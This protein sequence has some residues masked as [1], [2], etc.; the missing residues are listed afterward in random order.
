MHGGRGG[1]KSYVVDKS[2]ITF[3]KKQMRY[4]FQNSIKQ[5]VHALIKDQ[6]VNLKL[7]RYFK[8]KRDEIFCNL[9]AG[10]K[11]TTTNQKN[12]KFF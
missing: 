10:V 3:F 11:K 7:Q 5:G 1:G 6:I 2:L 9:T 8:V 4:Q 12:I